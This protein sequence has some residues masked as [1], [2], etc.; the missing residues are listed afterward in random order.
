[1]LIEPQKGSYVAR[2]RLDDVLQWMTGPPRARGRGRRRG[3]PPPAARRPR[4]TM[5]PQ[6][7]LPGG[8][9]RRPRLRR[10]PAARRRLPPAADRRPGAAPR[11]RDAR[12]AAQAHLDRVRRL[13]L[14]EPGRMAAT[15]AEHRAILDAIARRDPRR[16]RAGDAAPPRH[17]ARAPDRLRAPAPRLLQGLISHPADPIGA[18]APRERSTHSLPRFVRRQIG[19]RP[20]APGR[21]DRRARQA[22]APRLRANGDAQPPSPSALALV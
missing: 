2:I 8:G 14:P 22:G 1:M 18:G 9:D 15:L 19:A 10:L 11:G 13:L 21:R 5:R 20:P 6:P 17:R 7:A 4:P 16:G 3:R 12:I